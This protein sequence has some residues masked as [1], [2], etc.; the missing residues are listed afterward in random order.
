MA[1]SS[2]KELGLELPNRI[3]LLSSLIARKPAKFTSEWASTIDESFDLYTNTKTVNLVHSINQGLME[4]NWPFPAYL[5]LRS[6]IARSTWA[7]SRRCSE[8]ARTLWRGP[9][10]GLLLLTSW[11]PTGEGPAV[12]QEHLDRGMV[13]IFQRN[14]K[15]VFDYLAACQSLRSK[16]PVVRDIEKAFEAGLWACCITTTMPLLDLVMRDYFDTQRLSVSIQAL[17]D[18]FLK[19]A[20]LRPYD[21]MPGSAIWDAHERPDRGNTF[22]KSLEEDLRLPGIYLSSFFEFADRYYRFYRSAEEAPESPLNRHAIIHCSF[23]LWTVENTVRILT[24]LDL[25]LRLRK[26]LRIL[27]RGEEALS[28][29]RS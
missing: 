19:E 7:F 6:E 11:D 21:L 17:R 18:A 3:R 29:L 15:R 14:R 4:L 16:T 10:L 2:M 9:S 26:P 8:L 23:D 12:D 27:I 22:A 25:T 5:S 20:A 24:F 28:E 13:Y 1:K